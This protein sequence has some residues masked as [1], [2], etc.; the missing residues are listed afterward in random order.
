MMLA[1]LATLALLV[2][3][4]G[5]GDNGDTDAANGADA[6]AVNIGWIPWDEDVAVTYLWEYLLEEEGYDVDLTQ[7]DV[8]PVYQG[9][10]DGDI[11]VFLDAW[12]PQTHSDYWERF[13]DDLED[14]GVWYDSGTLNLA[15]PTYMDVE[16]IADLQGQADTFNGRIV[17]IEPGAGLMRVTREEAVPTY[18][19]EDYEVLEGSTPAM[20]AELERALEREEPIVVTLW[21]PHWAYAA[22]DIKDLEDPEGAMGGAEN[23]HVIG[24]SGFSDDYPELAGWLANFEMPDDALASLEQLI[25]NDYDEGEEREA[26]EEWLSDPENRELADGWLT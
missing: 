15:V 23:L 21:H 13:G 12:L 9:L 11:D 26:V 8:A 3:A 20:L 22:Y 19:L 1:L 25:I 14:V 4:C 6:Q 5:N 17:G 18:G 24:R 7:L 16:T 10:A 2:A